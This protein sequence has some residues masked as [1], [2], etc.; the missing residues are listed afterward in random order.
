[1][2][3][4]IADIL[5]ALAHKKDVDATITRARGLVGELCAGYPVYQAAK[6]AA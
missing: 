6:K 4:W 3:S 1:V 2:A 5:D